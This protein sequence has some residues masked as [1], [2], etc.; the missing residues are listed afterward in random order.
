MKRPN[1]PRKLDNRALMVKWARKL[2]E[3]QENAKKEAQA[4]VTEGN[5][6]GLNQASDS[7]MREISSRD[8]KNETP[9]DDQDDFDFQ[10]PRI[11]TQPEFVIPR[12][13]AK[14][15]DS[16]SPVL[17]ISEK[18][19]EAAKAAVE[20]AP[21]TVASFQAPIVEDERE[22]IA[23]VDT[24]DVNVAADIAVV[25]DA[26]ITLKYPDL[27]PKAEA[28]DPAVP[29][30]EVA[31]D[32]LPQGFNP[33]PEV[34][35]FE[36]PKIEE[37]KDLNDFLE[38]APDSINNSKNSISDF[39]ADLGI[40]ERV[41][42]LDE[43]FKKKHTFKVGALVQPIISVFNKV[44]SFF[45]S[46]AENDAL[47]ME[48][49]IK[50][51]LAT[52][53]Q[54]YNNDIAD[55]EDKYTAI[56]KY[57]ALEFGKTIYFDA[58]N[59]QEISNFVDKCKYAVLSPEYSVV[60]S[61]METSKTDRTGKYAQEKAVL[62]KRLTVDEEEVQDD[63]TVLTDLSKLKREQ[64]AK[65][66]GFVA[67]AV[68]TFGLLAGGLG[69]TNFFS[70]PKMDV[71]N[72][73]VASEAAV[74]EKP[75]WDR[76]VGTINADAVVETEV[77]KPVA[78]AYSAPKYVAK[79]IVKPV[80]KIVEVS[81]QLTMA[82][83]NIALANAEGKTRAFR[84]K[85]EMILG[86]DF[87]PSIQQENRLMDL[88]NV[89][90]PQAKSLNNKADLKKLNDTF[91]AIEANFAQLEKER[92]ALFAPKYIASADINSRLAADQMQVIKSLTASRGHK[93][94]I[95]HVVAKT[96]DSRTVGDVSVPYSVDLDQIEAKLNKI[97]TR[98]RS[99][100]SI[101]LSEAQAKADAA[102][103]KYWVDY[104]KFVDWHVKYG[105]NAKTITFN[106]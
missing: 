10:M 5:A 48:V 16:T 90:M 86:T 4:N 99:P 21:A 8:G 17:P 54:D 100:N 38:R 82:D 59:D 25:E 52:L 53:E 64:R 58:T 106:K 47:N 79:T 103:A 12:I 62:E 31:S 24:R 91:T 71:S 22:A 3:E 42:R 61:I 94:T 92:T 65:K 63:L 70:K 20:T 60:N 29:V 37:D 7:G 56:S 13:T 75:I 57:I 77:K 51:E 87:L 97:M 66:T 11:S 6:S 32:E 80:Q 1:T 101:N 35:T 89:I 81:D 74:N 49:K 72:E 76:G 27:H 68:A 36:E 93:F 73:P 45:R 2:F 46:K 105:Q 34:L 69:V 23:P 33:E 28:V 19:A 9:K 55:I 98:V 67:A 26:P 83:K 18:V 14:L 15:P 30:T 41:K 102:D 95:H 88:I 96:K 78:K 43:E 40:K 104:L 50:S 44:K 39:L 84:D 85:V